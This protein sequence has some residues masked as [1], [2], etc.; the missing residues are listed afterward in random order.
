MTL[1][2]TSIEAYYDIRTLSTPLALKVRSF[3]A[4]NP[5]CTNEDISQ[6]LRLRI[7]TVTPRVK[8]LKENGIVWITGR[9]RTSTGRTAN[10]LRV[11]TCPFCMSE[12]VLAN[13]RDSVV[14]DYRCWDCGRNFCARLGERSAD[15]VEVFR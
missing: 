7:Q 10:T 5:D 14:F 13:R 15:V 4:A 6:G 1:S 11:A 8:E 9:A 2:E 3:I 12:H